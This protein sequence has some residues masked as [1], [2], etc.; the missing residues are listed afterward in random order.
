MYEI[1]RL[2]VRPGYVAQYQYC[3]DI[4]E[5]LSLVLVPSIAPPKKKWGEG[6]KTFIIGVLQYL[7]QVNRK[8]RRIL[9]YRTEFT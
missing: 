8:Q 4:C 6:F 1:L 7:A 5:A 9:K 2:S 3:F